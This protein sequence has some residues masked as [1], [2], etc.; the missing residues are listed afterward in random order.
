MT[1]TVILAGGRTPIGRLL[2]SLRDVT[3]TQLGGIAIR[4]AIARSGLGAADVDAV[5]LGNVVQEGV[6]PNPAR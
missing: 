4:E 3:A 5:V 6:G 2:G 1:E